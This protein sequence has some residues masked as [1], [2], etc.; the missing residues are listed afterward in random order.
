MKIATTLA[1]AAA[2]ALSALASPLAAQDTATVEMTGALEYVPQT[3]TVDAGGTVRWI[4]VSGAVH[5][6]T[7][8]PTKARDPAHVELPPGAEPFDSGF[9]DPGGQY[10]H[11]FDVPGRYTY[12]CIPH[13][14]AGMIGEVIVQG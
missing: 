4:N 8:D 2:V 12:F 13:E 7:A 1:G 5:T 14:G 11:S 3:V 9:V 6:V 10:S